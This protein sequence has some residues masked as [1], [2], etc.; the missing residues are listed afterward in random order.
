MAT[1]PVCRNEIAVIR[2]RLSQVAKV[3]SIFVQE[4]RGELGVFIVVPEK[5][6]A[7]ER[8]IYDRELEIMD[9]C[10]NARFD[11]RVISLRGRRMEEIQHPVGELVFQQDAPAGNQ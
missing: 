2:Q 3:Q 9:D 7:L 1:V 5:D 10:P 4:G 6:F 8:E 11:F